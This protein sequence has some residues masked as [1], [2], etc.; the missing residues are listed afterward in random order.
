MF[1]SSKIKELSN[2]VEKLEQEVAMLRRT[3]VQEPRAKVRERRKLDNHFHEAVLNALR[4]KTYPIKAKTIARLAGTTEKSVFVY[5]SQMRRSG[6][7]VFNV[8]GK[9]YMLGHV[10]ER[11]KSMAKRNG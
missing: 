5:V 7:P 1:Y 4:D 8:R 6:V 11:Y 10:P 2:R 3:K 9:G